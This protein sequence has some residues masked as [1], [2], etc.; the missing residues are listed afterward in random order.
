MNDELRDRTDETLRANAFLGSV[1]SGIQQAVVV[2]DRELHVI[3]WNPAAAE[4]WGMRDDEVEG[5]R[6]PDLDI[7]LPL[8]ALRA[9][10][11]RVLAGEESEPVTADGHNR[12]GKAVTYTVAFAP[13][14]GGLEVS[15]VGTIMLVSAK[16]AS[17]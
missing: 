13:L 7:G 17:F 3:A 10:I 6:F 8:E 11:K 15:V 1:L 4:L 14:R 12:R 16:H 5:R 9:P 2:V